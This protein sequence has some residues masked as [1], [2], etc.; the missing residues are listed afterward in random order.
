VRSTWHHQR[1]Y[2]P[3]HG[4]TVR[5]RE[6]KDRQAD[7]RARRAKLGEPHRQAAG[8]TQVRFVVCPIRLPAPLPPDVVAALDVGFE[9]TAGIRDRGLGRVI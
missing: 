6:T 9:G 1:L 3:A 4:G 7:K 8:L 2:P 5:H